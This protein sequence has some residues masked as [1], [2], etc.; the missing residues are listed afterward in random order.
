MIK[1]QALRPSINIFFKYKMD[2]KDRLEELLHVKRISA[3]QFAKDLG[4][5][6]GSKIHRILRGEGMPSYE[7]ITD[8]AKRFP[9]VSMD[10]LISGDGEMYKKGYKEQES[11]PSEAAEG[12]I[13]YGGGEVDVDD[14]LNKM[15]EH[16][17]EFYNMLKVI[18]KT[19]K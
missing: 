19:K 18:M 13:F 1:N 2:F 16:Q 6:S 7:M 15:K 14:M 8:I 10:W 4:Y 9:D 12:K 3:N 5:S 17:E 11:E